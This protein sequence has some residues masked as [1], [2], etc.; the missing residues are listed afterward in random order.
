MTREI[1]QATSVRSLIPFMKDQPSLLNPFWKAPHPNTLTLG[2]R[3]QHMNF[4]ETHNLDNSSYHNKVPQTRQLS[5]TAETYENSRVWKSGPRSLKSR[6]TEGHAPSE[7]CSVA[8]LG[9]WGLLGIFSI[10][11]LA[12]AT[13]QS[14]LWHNMTLSL[15]CLSLYIF[16]FP[17]ECTALL[18]YDPVLYNY[19]WNGP[20]PSTTE[21]HKYEMWGS[22]YMQIYFTKYVLQYYTSTIG[23]TTECGNTDI[24]SWL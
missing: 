19:I 5:K 13:F 15:V 21:Q 1:S 9:P 11:R 10:S 22:T 16:S 14:L 18:Q 24:N 4:G 3:S 17:Y 6:C 20:I 12:A 7:N 8:L 23:W 2:I